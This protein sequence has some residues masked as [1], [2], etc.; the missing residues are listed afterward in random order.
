MIN[1]HIAILCSAHLEIIQFQIHVGYKDAFWG[2]GIIMRALFDLDKRSNQCQWGMYWLHADCFQTT[3]SRY[4]IFIV[5]N[6]ITRI[7]RIISIPVVVK[8]QVVTGKVGK[9]IAVDGI[10]II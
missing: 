8:H 5:E 10:C 2:Q 4:F 7:S 1:N 6:F 9:N 3:A